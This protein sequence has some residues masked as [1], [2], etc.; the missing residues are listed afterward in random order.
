MDGSGASGSRSSQKSLPNYRLVKTLGR[1][2]FGKV[3]LAFHILTGLKVAI[4]IFELRSINDSSA[5]R[6]R[7]EINIMKLF[8][9]PHVVRLYEVIE[10]RSRIYVVMELMDSGEL[11]DYI[12]ENS[13]LQEDEARHFFQQII[14]GVEYCHLK[15]V[16]HRDLKPENLLL[17]SNRSVKIADFGLSN[18]MRDGCFLKTSCGSPN[19][20]APEVISELLYAGPEVD[21]WSCGVILYALLCGTLPFDDDNLSGLYTRIKSG[22]YKFPNHLSRGA[23]DL[24]ARILIVDPIKRISIPEIRRHPWFQ[25]HLPQCMAMRS[26]DETYSTRGI[27]GEIVQEVVNIGFNI[28]TV[29]ESLQ[30]R[31]QNEATIAYYLLLDNHVQGDSGNLQNGFPERP[32]YQMDHPG[33]YLRPIPLAQTKWALGFQSQASPHGTM[34]DVLKVLQGLNVRWKKIGHY[35]MKCLWLP[36]FFTCSRTPLSKGAAHVDH[37]CSHELSMTSM[38]TVGISSQNAVKFEIQLYKA[39]KELCLLDFQRIYGPPF[40]FL[41]ICAAFDAL[42]VA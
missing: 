5:E 6:V 31:L 29:I 37:I 19:Y 22:I 1:G 10:T 17:N 27:D 21:V 39:N 32:R 7:R 15:N 30:N 36:P 8:A 11:F 9:H 40:L 3:K 26:I 25:Q 33:I 18:I 4:K 41:E 13:R 34:I 35:R 2:A 16:V 42:M 20:A 24:I 23:R 38:N 28:K 12:T 14:S